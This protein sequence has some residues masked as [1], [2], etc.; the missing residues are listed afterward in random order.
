[1]DQEEIRRLV[2]KLKLEEEAD[3]STVNLSQHLSESLRQKTKLCLVG[4]VFAGHQINR[5]LLANHLPSI[6]QAQQRVDIEIVGANL[7]VALFASTMDRKHVLLGGPWHLFQDLMLFKK[8]EGFQNPTDV[9]FDEFTGW[10]QCHNMPIA[11]MHPDVVRRI[12]EQIGV[13]EE[14]DM[15]VG[16][17]CM[18]RF[19]RVRVRWRM[20]NPLKRCV[21]LLPDGEME[22]AIVLLLYEKLPNFCFACGKIGHLVRFCEDKKVDKGGEF[23]FGVWLM[24]AKVQETRRKSTMGTMPRKE[25]LTKT[26][27]L[28]ETTESTDRQI[29][30]PTFSVN[31]RTDEESRR[32]EERRDKEDVQGDSSPV[33]QEV[34]ADGE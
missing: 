14:I 18:G 2:D 6:L 16:G 32:V 24:A 33:E 5:E 1:M 26:H 17:L 11:C 3:E 4:K 13:V 9:R 34:R 30:K 22:G 27:F 7:F 29:I 23:K 8:L 31:S 12:G 10:V 15:G 25:G 20:D 28:A 19:A 21:R